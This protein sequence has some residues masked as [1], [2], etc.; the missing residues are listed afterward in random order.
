MVFAF[1]QLVVFFLLFQPAM[2][3]GLIDWSGHYRFE[4]HSI[5]DLSLDGQAGDVSYGTHHLVLNPT[6]Q[7]T[8]TIEIRGRF[9]IFNDS[10]VDQLGSLWGG[11]DTD[12]FAGSKLAPR[13]VAVNEMYLNY[14]YDNFL[15]VLGRAPLDFGLGILNNSGHGDYDHWLN[16]RDLAAV[17]VEIGN[18]TVT[19]MYAKLL[20]GS[21]SDNDDIRD[22]I[23][24]L[25]YKRP[26]TGLDMGLYFQKR[27][28]SQGTFG[29]HTGNYFQDGDLNL[30]TYSLFIKRQYENWGW[31]LEG[32][33]QSGDLGVADNVTGSRVKAS[34]SVGVAAEVNYEWSK[35]KLNFKLGY[36]S[37][38]DDS[39]TDT[40][41]GFTFARNYDVA[42]LMFN[43]K[44][45]QQDL[46]KTNNPLN[47]DPSISRFDKEAISNAFYIAPMLSYQWNSEWSTDVRI[48][49]GFMD[50]EF[51]GSTDKDLGYEFDLFVNW[52]PHERLSL[53]AGGAVLLPGSAFE[54][55][56]SA[57]ETS[58]TI[59]LFTKAVVHF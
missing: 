3:Y 27:K 23:I 52:K 49:A 45:G 59:G 54:G 29:L 12:P 41:E 17:K 16:S 9:D 28:A 22:F 24:Q 38:D 39:T 21:I 43:Y 7:A 44:L 33:T 40:Y 35:W 2:A 26:D 37:G 13:D 48:T 57:F 10:D 4:A 25:D 34:G 18:F 31:S 51:T 56:S 32:A 42:H 14:G 36:A 8:D 50:E 58:T 46:L 20:E 1:R 11:S 15:F 6:I 53:T 47:N 19:P 30:T 5:D 55:G